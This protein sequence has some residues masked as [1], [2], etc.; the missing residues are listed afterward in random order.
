MSGFAFLHLGLLR[1]GGLLPRL[2]SLAA[3]AWTAHVQATLYIS[4]ELTLD[5]S[6]GIPGLVGDPR[7]VAFDAAGNLYISDRANHR[8]FKRD[9]LG[10]VSTVAGT[11]LSG[12]SG[13]GGPATA[14]RLTIPRSVVADAAGNLYVAD[15]GNHRI[16]KISANG[17]ISTVAGTGTAGFNGD[18]GAATSATLSAPAAV[19]VDAAGN[20]FI[21][22]NGNHRI[23]K[24]TP[25]GTIATVA[26]NGSPSFGGDGGL[27]TL[28]SLNSPTGIAVTSA[29]T[30]YIADF[31]NHRIRK[32]A[33]GTITTVA[34]SGTAGFAGDGASATAAFLDGPTAVALDAAGNLFISDLNNNRIRRVDVG[35]VIN[36]VAGNGPVGFVG[37]A[38][39]AAASVLSGPRGLALDILGRLYVADTGNRS[40]RKISTGGIGTA[41]GNGSTGLSADGVSSA[42]T[43]LNQPRGLAYA[44]EYGHYLPNLYIADSGNDRILKVDGTTGIVSTVAG[45]GSAIAGSGIATQ[46]RLS[47][48]RAVA[49]DSLTGNLYVADYG[50]HRVLRVSGGSYSTVAGGR[51]SGFG[52][53]GGRADLATLSFPIGIAVDSLSSSSVKRLYIADSGNH[54]IRMIENLDSTLASIST[55]AGTGVAGYSGDGVPAVSSQLNAPSQVAVDSRGYLYVSDT[56]NNRIRKVGNLADRV[57]TTVAGNGTAGFSG[58]GGL[59]SAAMISSPSGLVYDEISAVNDDKLFFADRANNRI[60]VV[61]Q[62]G[63]I[64]TVVGNGTAGYSGDGDAA[65]LAQLSGP[66]GIALHLDVLNSRPHLFIADLGNNRIREAA[67][68]HPQS[69]N[70][71]P[72]SDQTFGASSD[73][74][75]SA[76]ATS[77]LRVTFSTLT[78]STCSLSLFA[79]TVQLLGP[80]TCSIAASQSG[81]GDWAPAA[82]VVR[83]FTIGIPKTQS[84]V[85]L[86]SAPNPSLPGQLVTF[87]A[88]VTG[89]SPTGAVQFKDGAANLGEPVM[90]SD[91]VAVLASNGL[92]LGGHSITAAYL[93]DAGN[94]TSTSLAVTQV[95]SQVVSSTTLSVNP[96]DP[97]AGQTVTLTADVTGLSPSGS[98]QF[99]DGTID[100][101]TA[102]TMSGGTATLSTNALTVGVHS[103]TAV[104]LGDVNNAASTSPAVSRTVNKASSISTLSA[105]LQSPAFGAT[106]T[107]TAAVSGLVPTGTVQFFDGSTNLGTSALN[108][109]QAVFSIN[110]LAV[111]GHSISASYSGDANNLASTS[112]ALALTVTAGQAGGGD[113]DIPTL[114]EWG[115]ILL[116]LTLLMLGMRRRN[117]TARL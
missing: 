22:D 81:G 78:P 24:V 2:I 52:G 35:G 98:V 91:G 101:G 29:G 113:A 45:G 15:T 50:N 107:L 30:L 46:A 82:Q 47:S 32:V 64:S 99:K 61:D 16:R 26:G 75:F 60:R 100:L 67:D 17:T 58:D 3:L 66:Y 6:T 89:S 84:Q 37:D 86:S 117:L 48:P 72:L 112:P 116:G 95:V 71:P 44:Y 59:A 96:P 111:G 70:F 42:A 110:T 7:G 21:S 54:R 62:S 92:A 38:T 97:A 65:R 51:G 108:A 68:I 18:G 80:G 73:P 93:G 79:D 88:L 63:V 10:E 40:V 87:T 23:R 31:N 8:I 5:Q 102:V 105:S 109:G 36:T 55:V 39:D 20:L 106:V 115:A 33:A 34:G 49:F 57:I 14:A 74:F 43:T 53:D 12:F 56:G 13:D 76:V 9:L 94:T 11:G 1:L 77:G 27:A 69:I 41:V 103:L 25:V 85:Q 83:S 19:V 104:Y 90:L 114:P 4:T 28:A